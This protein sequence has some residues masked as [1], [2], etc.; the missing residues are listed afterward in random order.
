MLYKAV[1]VGKV[2]SNTPP[3]PPGADEHDESVTH[4]LGPEER[5]T[6]PTESSEHGDHIG[7]YRV[8]REIGKGGMG[9]V[10]LCHDPRLE[11][12]VAVK[13][14]TDGATRAGAPLERFR[15]EA[16]AL[17]RLNNPHVVRVLDFDD[18]AEPPFL[19]MEFIQGES[20]RRHFGATPKP[21]LR[22]IIDCGAQVLAGLAAAHAR[23]VVHR[24]I[25][26][27]NVLLGTDGVY[28]LLDFGL[29]RDLVVGSTLTAPQMV[30]GTGRYLAPEL[31]RGGSASVASDLYA[32]GVMMYEMTVGK[33]PFPD[34]EPQQ[35]VLLGENERFTDLREQRTDIPDDY[36]DWIARLLAAKPDRR[37][38]T[39]RAALD[40][41]EV[42]GHE[43]AADPPPQVAPTAT[44]PLPAAGTDGLRTETGTITTHRPTTSRA[45]ISAPVAF[46][47]RHSFFYRLLITIWVLASGASLMVGY[48]VGRNSLDLQFEKWRTELTT[49]ATAATLHIDP[50]RFA[51]LAAN[52]S[53]DHPY[54]DE[55]RDALRRFASINTDITFIY[56]MAPIAGETESRGLLQF[57][58]D[59]SIEEDSDGDGVIDPDERNA[60]PGERYNAGDDAPMMLEGLKVPIADRDLTRDQWGVHLS[61]YAPIITA[62][63]TVAGLIGIDASGTHISELESSFMTHVAL[64]ELAILVAFLA[65][66]GVVAYRL[67]RPVEA[68][69]RAMA[70]ISAGD[71]DVKVPVKGNNEFAWLARSVENMAT[72]LRE[73]D[74]LRAAFEGFVARELGAR[75]LAAANEQATGGASVVLACNMSTVLHTPQDLAALLPEFFDVVLDHGGRLYEA[76]GAS[77]VVG[78]TGE[79][80]DP[81]VAERAART[82]LAIHQ[83]A[84][85]LG[86]AL[87]IGISQGPAGEEAVT[88]QARVLARSGAQLGAD[89]LLSAEAFSPIQTMFIADRYAQVVLADGSHGHQLAALK[90]AV[91]S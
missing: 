23:G 14:I 73:R 46:K 76:A 91:S 72:K 85:G 89:I 69:Q 39:A 58:V 40:A 31:L 33:A 26:P 6:L 12:D 80:G 75:A 32:F 90:A 56:T 52:P 15:S 16:R 8:L 27:S 17:A 19:V 66:A 9:A 79:P 45:Q 50:E 2:T 54:H 38:P 53:V 34:V 47:P 81:T 7:R 51:D 78:F 36:A 62:D 30:L 10:Y 87:H 3:P 35:R 37:Y 82:A 57:V 41:L 84:G 49:G 65:A 25:K 1:R 61:G 67:Q 68:I 88:D 60:E 21:D 44:V 55:L 42:A 13:V 22:R 83:A 48:G 5:D 11:R 86:C 64:M 59:A 71:L 43:L 74:R 20:V 18:Q 24:D 4:P 63:G 70:K 28:R 77:L 29:A